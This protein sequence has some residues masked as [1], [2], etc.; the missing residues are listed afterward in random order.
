MQQFPQ[1]SIWS[2][3]YCRS[4]GELPGP[5]GGIKTT[6]YIATGAQSLC[7]MAG[8]RC[9]FAAAAIA[10]A[11][12]SSSSSTSSIRTVICLQEPPSR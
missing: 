4:H 7:Q 10:G 8:C 11:A 1:D 5:T 2:H 12:A 9:S 3:W 6:T